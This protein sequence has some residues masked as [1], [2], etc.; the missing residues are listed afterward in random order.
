MS[1]PLDT[2]KFHPRESDAESHSDT[3]TRDPLLDAGSGRR[4]PPHLPRN[5]EQM[6]LPLPSHNQEEIKGESCSCLLR[7]PPASTDG[8][9]WP[10]LVHLESLKSPNGLTEICKVAEIS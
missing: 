1:L 5:Q 8:G 10:A 3:A 4:F 7:T 2:G 6:L 9:S